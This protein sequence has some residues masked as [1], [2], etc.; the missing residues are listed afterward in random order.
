MSKKKRIRKNDVELT[1][2]L[3]EGEQLVWKGQPDPDMMI[4]ERG[5]N[6]LPIFLTTA[7]LSVA[8]ASVA[9]L[10]SLMTILGP[11]IGLLAAFICAFIP[12][13][14]VTTPL[15]IKNGLRPKI[16]DI[17][18]VYAITTHR[19]LR[20]NTYGYETLESL[21]IAS[22]DSTRISKNQMVFEVRKIRQSHNEQLGN[23]T[24][25]FFG[26]SMNELTDVYDLTRE[27]QYLLK[28]DND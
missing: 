25:A 21:N 5:V 26:L 12:V 7:P 28:D 17:Y 27:Q 9:F 24:I 23:H 6:Y 4:L 11:A 19:I 15:G 18:A 3:H 2:Y 1:P 10:I 13:L 22:L 20:L 16:E 8:V 14:L